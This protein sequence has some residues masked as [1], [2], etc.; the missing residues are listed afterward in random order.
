MLA[1]RNEESIRVGIR[2]LAMAAALGLDDI[3]AHALASIGIG[4]SRLGDPA[5]EADL[6]E[7]IALS[8]AGNSPDLARALNNLAS[9]RARRGDLRRAGELWRE[10]R[11]AAL[12]FGN[13]TLAHFVRSNLALSD[14]AAGR[15]DEALRAGAEMIAEF[16]AGSRASEGPLTRFIR[17]SIDLARGEVEAAV[18]EHGSRWQPHGGRA[19][20]RISCPPS[21]RRPR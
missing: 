18:G 1:G 4:R 2:A 17:A 11:Q 8:R 16:E 12:D 9:I 13:P 7:A 10:A 20:R 14:Y 3:R 5:G 15:W 6:E 19:T 21:R